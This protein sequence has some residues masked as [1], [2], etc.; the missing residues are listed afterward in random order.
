MNS[1]RFFETGPASEYDG[2][3]PNTPAANT[4]WGTVVGGGA[5][6]AG[7]SITMQTPWPA[8]SLA[9]VLVMFLPF[10]IWGVVTHDTYQLPRA[11]RLALQTFYKLPADAQA[12]LGGRNRFV[13][14]LKYLSEME[15]RDIQN[16]MDNIIAIEKTASQKKVE[17][18]SQGKELS[19]TLNRH[20]DS[21][22]AEL[23]ALK[24]LT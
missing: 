6:S 5:L 23:D 10:W 16:Q 24:E 19:E 8:I 17:M 11:K 21:V 3:V 2:T 13:E 15:L 20:L 4:F 14:E 18:R 1:L 9:I 7:V 22:R 12:D